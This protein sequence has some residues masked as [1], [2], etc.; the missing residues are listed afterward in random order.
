LRWLP[1]SSR[2]TFFAFLPYGFTP[3]DDFVLRA[4]LI[5]TE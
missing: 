3:I 5:T 1:F 4:C 2:F